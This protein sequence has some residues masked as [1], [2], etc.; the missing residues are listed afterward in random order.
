MLYPFYDTE[1][2]WTKSSLELSLI[3]KSLSKNKFI[4]GP[5]WVKEKLVNKSK[6]N[7][8]ISFFTSKFGSTGAVNSINYI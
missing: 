5:L 3:N 8:N 1:L 2:H 4:I 7:L 6:D